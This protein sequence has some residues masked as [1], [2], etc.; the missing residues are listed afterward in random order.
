MSC[1]SI[2][3]QAVDLHPLVV[4]ETRQFADGCGTGLAEYAVQQDFPFDGIVQIILQ[5][6]GWAELTKGVMMINAAGM[7]HRNVAT[8]CRSVWLV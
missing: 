5:L 6:D 4:L 8:R 2:H 7:N 1:L 3:D